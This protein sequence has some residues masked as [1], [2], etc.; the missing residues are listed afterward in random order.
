MRSCFNVDSIVT[1][2]RLVE[3]RK[4]YYIPPKYK[5]HVPLSGQ[6]LY[7]TFSSSFGLSTDALEAGLRFP[8]HPVIEAWQISPSHMGVKDMNEAWLSEAGLSPTPLGMLLLFTQ[9][10][11]FLS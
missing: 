8:L 4:H 3:V 6:R 2:H 11:E 5:L 9:H 10:I 1:A 7:D